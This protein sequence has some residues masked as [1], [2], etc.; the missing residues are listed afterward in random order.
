MSSFGMPGALMVMKNG[1]TEVALLEVKKDG[2]VLVL[3]D[4]RKLWVNPDDISYVQDWPPTTKLEIAR[5]NAASTFDV[6]VRNTVNR[7]EITARW[8]TSRWRIVDCC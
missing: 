8:I 2:K 1:V 3:L 5:G 4:G 6:S 7:D